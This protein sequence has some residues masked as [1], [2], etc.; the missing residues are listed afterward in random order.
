MSFNPFDILVVVLLVI[1]IIYGAIR[2]AG[3][4]IMGLFSAWLGLVICLWLYR[5]F[6]RNILMGLFAK[7]AGNSQGSNA[8]FD[9]FSFIMLLI[10]FAAILQF[11]FIQTTKSPEEKTDTSGKTFIEK[12]QQK[13]PLS[14]LNILGGLLTGFIVTMVWLSIFLAPIQFVVLAARSGGSF[15][16]GLRVAMSSSALL[17]FFKQTLTLIYLTIQPFTPPTGLP[18]IFSSFLGN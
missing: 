1:G 18:T 14:A 5:P 9:T 3:R 2:G 6:S 15:V 10:L 13:S 11:I 16:T 8:V 12:A 7:A 17:P 4:Q